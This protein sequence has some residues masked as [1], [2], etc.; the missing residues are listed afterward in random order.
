MNGIMGMTGPAARTE[1]TEEQQ[2]YAETIRQ[3]SI[4]AGDHKR[5]PGFSKIESGQLNWRFWIS[6]YARARRFEQ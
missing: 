2:E 5:D 6:T 1:L 4:L 3:R